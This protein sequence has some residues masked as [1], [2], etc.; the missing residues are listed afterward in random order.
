MA[1]GGLISLAAS[2]TIAVV[3]ARVGNLRLRVDRRGVAFVPSVRP[4]ELVK[5]A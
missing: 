3:L 1:A 4:R 5:V 2:A